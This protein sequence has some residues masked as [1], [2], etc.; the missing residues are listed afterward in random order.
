[1][2]PSSNATDGNASAKVM[3]IEDEPLLSE[4]LT[5][6]LKAEGWQVV[7]ASHGVD[8]LS[9]AKRE[10][11]DVAIVDVMIPGIDGVEVVRR[12]RARGDDTLVLF[13]TA[14]DALDDKIAGLSAGGDDYVTKP[15]S[16]EEVM[17]RVRG[18]IARRVEPKG[19]P[20]E[21]LLKVGDLELDPRTYEAARAG[22]LI[23][24]TATEF[25]LLQYLMEN[26]RHV[27]SKAQILD[28]VWGYDFGGNANVVEIYISYLRKKIDAL[29]P[30]MIHTLRS[31][32]YSIRPAEPQ[33]ENAT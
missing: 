29:G 6:A 25:A 20:G 2:E 11:P 22:T 31:V 18:M 13:L 21:Q 19:D 33:E 30:P 12:M 28:R 27:L 5:M 32:G 10:R 16:L 9:L 3:V 8:A 24:L 4:L 26:P 7:T 15:F 23:E 17:L 1:M 14:K